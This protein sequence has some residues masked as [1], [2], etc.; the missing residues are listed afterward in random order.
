MS[1]DWSSDVCSSDLGLRG[2]QASKVNNGGRERKIRAREV[3]VP[4]GKKGGFYMPP[5]EKR[6]CRKLGRIIR[7]KWGR[8]IRGP[9]Y[10]APIDQIIRPKS[11]GHFCMTPAKVLSQKTILGPDYP[12]PVGPE[13]PPHFGPDYLPL[14]PPR[15]IR[16]F[17]A[18]LS[19]FP[20]TDRNIKKET[21]ITF[22]YELRFQCSW[23]R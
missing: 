22:A 13:N 20:K 19:G 17:W 4:L 8:N 5:H 3:L 15:I 6:H 10:L 21:A 1:G 23:A 9:D 12:P 2:R 18:G 14:P 16:P 7:P 11:Q